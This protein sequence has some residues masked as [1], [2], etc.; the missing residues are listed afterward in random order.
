MSDAS[1]IAYRL[2][3]QGLLV[4]TPSMARLGRRAGLS[5]RA[6][7]RPPPHSTRLQLEACGNE[8][9]RFCDTV[10]AVVL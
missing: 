9:L 3:C 4:I 5:R 10:D 8:R 7:R 1:P 6:G 2:H